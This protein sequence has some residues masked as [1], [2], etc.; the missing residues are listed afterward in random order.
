MFINFTV[1]IHESAD[2]IW[3]L[4]CQHYTTDSF[5]QQAINNSTHFS[6]IPRNSQFKQGHISIQNHSAT[7]SVITFLNQ[8]DNNVEEW[9]K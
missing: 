1:P 3:A 5:P 9:L 4:I 6:M 7:N 8:I 2:N